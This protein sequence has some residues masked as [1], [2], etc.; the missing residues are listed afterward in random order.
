MKSI[1]SLFFGFMI[2]ASLSWSSSGEYI[3]NSPGSEV[4]DSLP[5]VLNKG[6]SDLTATRLKHEAALKFA[7]HTLPDNLADWK[8]YRKD[9]KDELIRKTGLVINHELALNM[10]EKGTVI[11]KGYS[12][13]NIIFQTR[14]GVY[15]T[16]NLFVP[17][18]RGPFPAVIN[19]LGHWTKGKIDSTGPQAVGH[20]LA[21]NGYVCLTV[22][23]W[24][25]GERTTTHGLF[26]DH[27]DGNN[28]G[29]SL[30]NI[31]ETM[32]GIEISDN[33][34][35]VDLLC[36]LPYVDPQKIG[37][38]GASGGGNQTMWLAAMDERIKAAM[39][40]VSVGS[41]ESYIMG[42]PCICEVLPDALT[43]TEEAGVLALV[44]PRAIKMCNHKKDSNPAF[45]PSEMIRS[46]NNAK[47]VFRMY[48]AEDN[49][50]FQMFDLPHGYMAEDRQAM[51]GWFDLHLRGTGTGAPK[52]EAPFD[53]LP[54]EKLM[55]FPRGQRD[56]EVITTEEY[57]RLRGNELRKEFLNITAFNRELK[58]DELKNILKVH[59]MPA[60][61]SVSRYPGSDSW[62]KIVLE[63]ADQ[64]LIPLLVR[65]AADYI[66]DF[67]IVCNPEGK[68][69]IPH[70]VIDGL[71][72][73]GKSVA[74]MEL[75]GTGELSP[76][77]A[78]LTYTKGG[79]RVISRS[80]LWFGRTMIG[81]WVQE[82]NAV[83]SFLKSDLR[84]G[85]IFLDGSREA[86]VAGLFLSA[87]EG[88]I[89]NVTLRDAPVSYLFDARASVDFFSSAVFLPG[90]LKWGDISLAAAL[91]GKDI[92]FIDP[93]TISGQKIS[94]GRL[95]ECR[96]E[97]EKIRRICRQPGKTTFK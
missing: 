65:S 27:G 97:F 59:S 32:M 57:C 95:D 90:F 75:S 69:R 72:K 11:M 46:Y 82:I 63:T 39:P 54:Q 28:L 70:E 38:T 3:T 77:S 21:V 83:A 55:V 88:T 9:L 48:G 53:Q 19:M 42:T 89:E 26:E 56:A 87:L 22:D 49:I 86:G 14:P 23:P 62:K 47:P 76:A 73:S 94:G 68:N 8:L 43:F 25:S 66:K 18:G 35:G 51:L 33:I 71:L 6:H 64:K 20:S 79:L 5:S 13:K 80:E 78:R 84:A 52:E 61:I 41:F 15:A 7:G 29:S 93:L 1:I 81:E 36:S 31:G 45:Y 92:I 85:K 74:V 58:K 4:S 37:A 2:S 24:G 96:T 12:V 10:K 60:V 91:T 50:A 44:A 34:R 16:A 40:V 30:M 67:V 17:D